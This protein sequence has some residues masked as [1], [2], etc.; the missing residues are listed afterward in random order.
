MAHHP[1]EELARSKRCIAGLTLELVVD[2][3]GQYCGWSR[4]VERAIAT[5]QHPDH[6]AGDN[7]RPTYTA[8]T[9]SAPTRR[10]AV[11]RAVET[12]R[13]LWT[14]GSSLWN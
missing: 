1:R 9:E 12:A 8:V 5:V 7:T 4:D 13:S 14:R 10:E 11:R 6:H 2:R 3:G